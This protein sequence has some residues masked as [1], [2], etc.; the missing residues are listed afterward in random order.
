MSKEL[1]TRANEIF[2]EH[3]QKN[4]VFFTEDGQAFF[5][6]ADAI[7]HHNKQEF[8]TE[9]KTFFREGFSPADNEDFEKAWA[10]AI[11]VNEAFSEVITTVKWVAN[12]ENEYE[13]ATK[14]TDETVTAVIALREDNDRLIQENKELILRI[15]ELENK[16]NGK[17]E[18]D[19]KKA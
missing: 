15:E 19:S 11:E 14:E 10:E 9:I 17:T 1:Q 3:P 7:N 5:N 12:T 6:K 16:D 18:T 8:E 4:E 13:P 2:K